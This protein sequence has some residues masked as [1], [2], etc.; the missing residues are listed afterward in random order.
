MSLQSIQTLED[1]CY[2]L[3][4]TIDV[5]TECMFNY[6]PSKSNE[7]VKKAIRYISKNFFNNL[8]L[9]DVAGHVHLNP[10]YFSTLFKQSTGSSFKEYLNMVRWKKVNSFLLTQT[11][12]LLKFL[13]QWDSKTRVIFLKY[14]KNT[15]A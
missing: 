13:W 14:L 5:F 1:L 9:D 7:I 15:P 8:T 10:S 2:K 11:I 4:E 12:P 3:Q 6:I